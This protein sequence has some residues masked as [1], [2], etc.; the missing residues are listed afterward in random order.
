M[1]LISQN[2][3]GMEFIG[4][5]KSMKMEMEAYVIWAS[6]RE[7]KVNNISFHFHFFENQ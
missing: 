3:N 7:R 1:G 5:G 4:N 6:N 2:G